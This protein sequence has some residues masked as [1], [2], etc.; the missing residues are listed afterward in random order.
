MLSFPIQLTWKVLA[1]PSRFYSKKDTA[2]ALLS[3]SIAHSQ[4]T[5]TLQQPMGVQISKASCPTF[6]VSNSDFM[7]Q[8]VKLSAIRTVSNQMCLFTAHQNP[9]FLKHP[10]RNRTGE[11]LHCPAQLVIWFYM[12]WIFSA[13]FKGTCIWTNACLWQVQHVA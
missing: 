4:V 12:V 6:L 10:Q 2:H 1:L 8:A 9:S 5:L 13:L 11:K 3:R 7:L